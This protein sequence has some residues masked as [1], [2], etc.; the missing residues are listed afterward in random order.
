M[1]NIFAILEGLIS[2]VPEAVTLYHKIVPLLSPNADI[3]PDQIAAINALVPDA[4]AAVT[5][6]HEAIATLIS[7]HAPAAG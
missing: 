1:F 5:L 2:S 3:H 6:A 7:T 4:T